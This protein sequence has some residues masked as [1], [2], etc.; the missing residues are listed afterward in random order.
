MAQ[1]R[2]LLGS[3]VLHAPL[4]VDVVAELIDSL[5][6]C[7]EAVTACAAGMV[8]EDDVDH[9]RRAILLDLDCNDVAVATRRM[10]TRARGG[11]GL[12]S[13]QLEACLLAC[14]RSHDECGQHS[15]H[16]E[17]CRLCAAATRRA[18]DACRRALDTLRA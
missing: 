8:F 13:I 2:E 9:L 1:T 5:S 16:H 15:A 14:E 7:E 10:I 11:D 4:S 12:L 3:M 17:H 18:A 6:E